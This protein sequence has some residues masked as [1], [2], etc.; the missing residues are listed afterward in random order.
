MTKCTKCGEEFTV[1]ADEQFPEEIDVCDACLYQSLPAEAFA[2]Y[3]DEPTDERT[4]DDD[5]I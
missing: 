5:D 1:N 4:P 3:N 2:E